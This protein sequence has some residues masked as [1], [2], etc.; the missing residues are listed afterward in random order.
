MSY[1]RVVGF[2]FKQQMQHFNIGRGIDSD[3]L[4]HKAA[5]CKEVTFISSRV[6]CF[7]ATYAIY[8]YPFLYIM[9]V[10]WC[11]LVLTAACRSR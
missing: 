1:M 6:A 5:C 7:S 9:Y 8:I 10:Y 3:V 11:I 2:V 4:T